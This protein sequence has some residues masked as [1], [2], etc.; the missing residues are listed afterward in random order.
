[1]EKVKIVII[2]ICIATI[3]FVFAIKEMISEFEKVADYKVNE[4]EKKIEDNR[5][6][7]PE[8]DKIYERD[9]SNIG[10]NVYYTDTVIE[11][12]GKDR[13]SVLNIYQVISDY[14][15]DYSE[16]GV[17]IYIE[18]FNYYKD[19]MLII[20]YQMIDGVI[21]SDNTIHITVD[22]NNNIEEEKIKNLLL[23]NESIL[24]NVNILDVNEVISTVEQLAIENKDKMFSVD[25][26]EAI[27]GEIYLEYE[28]NIGLYYKS[29]MNNG[30]YIEVDAITG[31]VLKTNFFDGTV[32]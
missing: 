29:I 28:E 20:A 17:K 12:K 7:K 5:Y 13:E 2:F 9:Y 4:L 3:S 11:I 15:N 30:S 23:K 27:F 25:S 6:V 31:E 10:E 18:N 32:Y 26:Q 22:R 8:K 16:Y 21:I 24:D 14:L 19:Q 1:M